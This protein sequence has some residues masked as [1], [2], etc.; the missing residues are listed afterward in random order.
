MVAN[1]SGTVL[2]L[3]TD[4][5]VIHVIHLGTD[6]IKFNAV[7]RKS[8]CIDEA[9][10]F[11]LHCKYWTP[12][13]R[14]ISIHPTTASE[15]LYYHLVAITSNGCRIY[16]DTQWNAQHV[17]HIDDAIPNGL[18][19]VHVRAPGGSLQLTDTISKP[20]YRNGLTM[21]VNDTSNSKGTSQIVTFAPAVASLYYR[22]SGISELQLEEDC[23]IINIPGK[24]I[25]VVEAPT[26]TSDINEFKLL[27]SQGLA[28]HFLIFTTTGV[29]ILTK[30]R[31]VDLLHHLLLAKGSNTER[32]VKYEEFLSQIGYLNGC[33]AC[34]DLIASYENPRGDDTLDN[35]RP[36]TGAVVDEAKA[37]LV[38][39]SQFR[40]D[41]SSNSVLHDG[42]TLFIQRTMINIWNKKLIKK[43]RAIYTNNIRLKEIN[44]C[45]VIFTQLEA[46]IIQIRRPKK[47]P[48]NVSEDHLL[49]LITYLKDAFVFFNFI[50]KDNLEHVNKHM[51]P[52]SQS[53]LE[54]SDIRSLLT[55][56][57]GVSFV[58]HNLKAYVG[59]LC[60]NIDGIMGFLDDQC[61]LLS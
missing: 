13:F 47:T 2:Y 41:S 25:A 18:Y 28:R 27:K 53:L 49:K 54:E 42:L 38:Y 37:L 50:F 44:N 4:Q 61:S 19:T 34:F 17:K 5:S 6:G 29:T 56:S 51:G 60:L 35:T 39:F 43:T 22:K 40:S 46:A 10:R 31:P 15:S 45:L 11:N 26:E 32:L 58:L 20:I 12:S 52:E 33:S 36:V 57:K 14:I 1:D 7:C 21:L 3:L 9:K 16:Y 48:S 24:V 8:D 55:A 30:Q 59:T 23:S